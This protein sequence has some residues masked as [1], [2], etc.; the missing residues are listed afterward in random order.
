MRIGGVEGQHIVFLLTDNQIVEES[1]L[2]D[3]NNVINSGEVP[4]L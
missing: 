4:N 2:E 3:V 1:F